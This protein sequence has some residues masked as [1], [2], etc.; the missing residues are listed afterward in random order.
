M[1][2]ATESKAAVVAEI[3]DKLTRAQGVVLVNY[4]G[5]T[6]QEVTALRAQFRAAGIDYKVYKNTLVARAANELGI[7]GMDEYLHG[8]TAF[9]FGYNDP[10]AP[11]K[12]MS[13]YIAKAKKME[14]KGGVLESKV[15]DASG[16]EG[17]SKLPSKE[18]MVVMLLGVMNAPARNFVSVLSGPARSLAQVLNAIKEKKG[19]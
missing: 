4:A 17:L 10:V 15:I 11:A 7:Q 13:D 12:V 18:I 3:K 14:I 5:I 9:A 1:S 16:V 8:S 6:V 19:A 2:N